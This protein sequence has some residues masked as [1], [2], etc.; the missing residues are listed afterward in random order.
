LFA[1]SSAVKIFIPS[2]V[3]TGGQN[4]TI[5]S[6]QQL[7]YR[8]IKASYGGNTSLL[9]NVKPKPYTQTV[10]ICCDACDAYFI[11]AFVGCL[12]LD[13]LCATSWT[14]PDWACWLLTGACVAADIYFLIWC[15]EHCMLC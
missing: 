9:H 8:V 3:S 2:S 6:T 1:I 10:G 15:R 11:A 4:Q 7:H 5:G 13:G 12:A 14:W